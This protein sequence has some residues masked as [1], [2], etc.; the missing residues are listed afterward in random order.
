MAARSVAAASSARQ[1]PGFRRVASYS[2]RASPVGEPFAGVAAGARRSMHEEAITLAASPTLQGV[3]SWQQRLPAVPTDPM[4]GTH[5]LDWASGVQM[6]DEAALAPEHES[7]RLRLSAAMDRSSQ[8]VPRGSSAGPADATSSQ[9]VVGPTLSS[10]GSTVEW[11]VPK[12]KVRSSATRCIPALV[13]KQG[14]TRAC[15][16]RS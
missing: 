1:F 9:R 5:D 12:W 15:V 14:D 6:A 10:S 3:P 2:P 11:K 7:A 4:H 13:T 8:E 16:R